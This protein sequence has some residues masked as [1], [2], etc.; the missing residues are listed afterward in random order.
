MSQSAKG[1]SA[2][3]HWH[4]HS[5]H[6]RPLIPAAGYWLSCSPPKGPTSMRDMCVSLTNYPPP[7]QYTSLPSVC[8]LPP[9]L[10]LNKTKRYC[11]YIFVPTHS[12]I[13]HPFLLSSPPFPRLSVCHPGRAVPPQ[14]SPPGLCPLPWV[15]CGGKGLGFVSL[16]RPW[17]QPQGERT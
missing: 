16:S 8:P 1:K 13:F 10:V 15:P 3:V 4:L 17:H 9:P 6:T 7:P 11:S 12:C 5:T 14:L 2:A